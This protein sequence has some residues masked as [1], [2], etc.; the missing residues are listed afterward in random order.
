KLK[1][2]ILDI[3]KEHQKQ[4]LAKEKQEKID[5]LVKKDSSPVDL[6]TNFTDKPTKTQP[7]N[8]PERTDPVRWVADFE[9]A[10]QH[11]PKQLSPTRFE[12]N[13]PADRQNNGYFLIKLENV[14]DRTVQIEFVSRRA[15]RNW[16][17][18]NPV[19]SYSDDLGDPANYHMTGE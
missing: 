13:L 12:V 11:K 6:N 2:P 17:T 15:E 9:C 19:Y 1:E 8:I 3:Y 18:L 4:K 14:K 10:L 16:G 5:R 7:K